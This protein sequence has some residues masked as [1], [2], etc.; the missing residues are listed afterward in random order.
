MAEFYAVL[1]SGLLIGMLFGIILQRGRFCMNSAFRDIILLKEYKLIKSVALALL[2][3]MAG[4]GIMGLAGW[5]TWNPKPLFAYGSIIGGFVFGLGMVLAAGCASGTT[6]RVG[7]GMMGSLVALVGLAI[8]AF[9]TKSGALSGV[10]TALQSV[11]TGGIT[12]FGD[13]TPLFCLIIG[14]IGL[15]VTFYFWVFKEIKAKREKFFDFSNLG[16]NIFKKGWSWYSTGYLIGIINIIAWP[17]SA[18]AGRNYPL[19]ITAGWIGNLKYLVTGDV[20]ALSWISWLVLGVIV[21]ALIASLIAG[22]FKLRTPKEGKTILLQFLG[23]FIM[24][25][26]AVVASGCNVGNLL[27]GI[28][29]LSVGSIVSSVG[30]V[31]GCWFLAF[32]LFR[33]KD[34]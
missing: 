29:Q 10:T 31:L 15:V 28:P 21:G 16:E 2:T 17:L 32:L 11:S 30:I 3:C 34:D 9:T 18:A 26:G 23:G 13:L 19:G 7:E 33:E 27:S 25:F 1:I 8:G 22:E 6:Y 20:A 14:V 12:V 24:G 5:V 4:F